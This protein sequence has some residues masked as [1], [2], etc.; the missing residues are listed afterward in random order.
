MLFK[1][2]MIVIQFSNHKS[3]KADDLK[4]LL[5]FNSCISLY[6]KLQYKFLFIDYGSFSI[7]FRIL[8]REFGKGEITGMTLIRN[9]KC[10][11]SI[12]VINLNLN[13]NKL[14]KN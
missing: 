1:V 10:L 12:H 3:T 5:L 2:N 6:I 13:F 9:N 8:H 14:A 11:P 7:H 4:I